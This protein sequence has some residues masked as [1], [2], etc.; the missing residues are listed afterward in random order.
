MIVAKRKA[1]SFRRLLMPFSYNEYKN[2]LGKPYL[3]NVAYSWK[4]LGNFVSGPFMIAA[5]NSN[6]AFYS[7]AILAKK[8]HP[9]KSMDHS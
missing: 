9:L 4:G 8:A 6:F 1:A 5:H 2:R 7:S 3:P